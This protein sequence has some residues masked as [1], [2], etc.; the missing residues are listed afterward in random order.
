M[1]SRFYGAVEGRRDEP[2]MNL[3][4][5][6]FTCRPKRFDIDSSVT[7]RTHT[8]SISQKLCLIPNSIPQWVLLGFRQLNMGGLFPGYFH[9][10]LPEASLGRFDH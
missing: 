10:L 5:E 8:L 4:F 6:L 7:Q 1:G 3:V 2:H 9:F